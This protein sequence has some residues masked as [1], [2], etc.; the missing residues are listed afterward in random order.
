MGKNREERKLKM[1]IALIFC[2]IGLA[3]RIYN[4]R[5][6]NDNRVRED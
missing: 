3:I 5:F 1:V 4:I 2:L 6:N